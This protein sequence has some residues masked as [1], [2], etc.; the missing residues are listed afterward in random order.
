MTDAQS[1]LHETSHTF[2]TP[3][4]FLSSD[5]RNAV[6][7]RAATARAGPPTRQ[8]PSRPRRVGVAG[9]WTWDLRCVGPVY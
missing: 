7:G 9:E 2:Y 1:M 3:T 6:M 4:M 5:L 8:V